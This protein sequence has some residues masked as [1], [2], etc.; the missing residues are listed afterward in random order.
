MVDRKNKAKEVK[1]EF[2]KYTAICPK[3]K[4]KHE[5]ETDNKINKSGLS[6][7]CYKCKTKIQYEEN[8]K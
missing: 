3:C 6:K 2:Y 1:A 7:K 4:V 5:I 8:K